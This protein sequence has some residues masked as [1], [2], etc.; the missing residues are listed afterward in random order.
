MS[1][2]QKL[3]NRRERHQ[4]T[5]ESKQAKE[6]VWVKVV[7]L[8]KRSWADCA[9]CLRRLLYCPGPIFAGSLRRSSPLLITITMTPV[10]R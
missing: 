6:E 3:L 9:V 1:G 8:V 5:K 7:R 4:V 2:F 10:R